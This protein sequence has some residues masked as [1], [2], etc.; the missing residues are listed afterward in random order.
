M[1]LGEGRPRFP[2]QLFQPAAAEIAENHPRRLQRVG[3]ISRFV[4]QRMRAEDKL[5]A[6]RFGEEYENWRH[7]TSRL[8]PGLY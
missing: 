6:G 1:R 7:R 5:L 8:L 4:A 2:E 3:G